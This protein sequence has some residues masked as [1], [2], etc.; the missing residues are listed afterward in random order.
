MTTEPIFQNLY[1]L[2]SQAQL[3]TAGVPN[4]TPAFVTTSRKAPQVSSVGAALQP[5]MYMMEGFE[6]APVHI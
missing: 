1:N 4:G 6:P 5:A 2:L 3:L